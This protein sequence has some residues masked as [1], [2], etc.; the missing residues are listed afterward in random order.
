M[1]ELELANRF[2]R[3]RPQLR[4]V[5]YRI[6][7]SLSE[8]D[9]AVQ[10]AWLRLQRAG[11]EEIDNL[12]GWLTTV[13]ARICLNMLRDALDPREQPLDGFVPEPI[14]STGGRRAIPST[15]R[16]WPTRS[17]SR[18]RS[19]WTRS[20]RPN[21]SRSCCTTCSRCRST[22][23]RRWSTARPRRPAS[24]P[25][26]P[27]AACGRR[28]RPGPRPTRQRAVVDAYFAAA[29]DGDLEALVAV[30]DPDVVLRAHRR[31]RAA[32]AARRRARRPRRAD[33]PAASRRSSGRRWST[34][35]PAW[36]RSTA[37]AV[38]GARVHHRRRPRS[39]DRRVQRPRT[40]T[41]A[42]PAR[43]L[44]SFSSPRNVGSCPRLTRAT[45][46]HGRRK[47]DPATRHAP[48]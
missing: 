33:G 22:R 3:E 41:Q 35:P 9:D 12:E 20:P 46:E 2:D 1:D 4:A 14:V 17:G 13:V 18:C 45:R 42:R 7:G 11:A 40:G 15:R 38:R 44:T 32:R 16:C 30:L 48:E 36:S 39:R 5:A 27:A 43:T 47:A 28:A 21:A 19:C 25:A 23:S 37:T 26:A 6:L 8:A 10:E 24:S 29:R 34:A 31:E